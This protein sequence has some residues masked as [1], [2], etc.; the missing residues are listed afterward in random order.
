M[1]LT[2]ACM[3]ES[4]TLWLPAD[5][6]LIARQWVANE[7]ICFSVNDPP[8][9]R[10]TGNRNLPPNI[11]S[12]I[13]STHSPYLLTPHTMLP[14]RSALRATT[15]ARRLFALSRRDA[16]SLILLEHKNG[17][18]NDSSLSAVTAAQKLDGDVPDSSRIC[19]LCL[20]LGRWDSHWLKGR[21]RWC[22]GRG[23][24]VGHL[25]IESRHG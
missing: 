21:R 14:L 6:S 11:I 16:S 10:V 3:H 4:V 17:K 23:Q 7:P 25:M 19:K 12:L 20:F 5:A 22:L 1:A 15:P 13:V 2:N 18:L 8:E 9:V 24:K